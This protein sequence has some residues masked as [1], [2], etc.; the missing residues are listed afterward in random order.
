[1]TAEER[2]SILSI[3]LHAAFADGLRHADAFV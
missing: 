3:A 1:M 2:G